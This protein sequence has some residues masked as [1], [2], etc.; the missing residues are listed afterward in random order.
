MTTTRLRTC[1]LCEATCGLVFELEDHRIVRVTGDDQHP[2]SQGYLCPKGAA[3]GELDADPDRLTQ[4]RIR[5]GD[6]WR[7]VDWDEA[8]AFIDDR[9]RHVDDTHG[10]ESVALYL[11]NPNVHTLAGQLYTRPFRQALR[12][13]VFVTASTV[14][15]M[16]KHR[17]CGEMFGDPAAIPVPDI[18]RTDFL[19]IIG[20]DPMMSNGS[21]WT[22][23]DI[24]GRLR[25]LRKRGGRV[26]VV[27]PRRSRTAAR[28]DLHL[29]IRPTTDAVL[30]AA[31]VTVLFDERLVDLGDLTPHVEG[32]DEV[33]EALAWATPDVA[34]ATCGIEAAQIRSLARDLA[35][36]EHAVVYGR[37]GTT[38]TPYGTVASWL[39]DVLNVLTGNLDRP[40]GAMFPRPWHEDRSGRP[41]ARFGRFHS[42]V[43]NHPEVLGE[44]PVAALAEEITTPGDGQVRALFC[45]AGNPVLSTPDGPVL[46]AAL[47]E[48]DLMVAVDPYVTAT[49][50]RAH[51]ILPP[52]PPRYSGHA[53]L[54]FSGLAVRNV[55]QY[56]PPVVP[57]PA[58]RPSE[59]AI[60]LRL[61]AIAQG[62]GP[63]VDVEA[64]D[65]LVAAGLAGQLA[66]RPTAR[67]GD[68]EAQELLAAVA[69][70][71]GA[72]RL[73]DLLLRS[74]PY[75]DA[76]GDDPDGWSLDRLAQHPH[77]VDLGALEPRVPGVLTTASG[78]IELAPPAILADVPR[79]QAL[80]DAVPAD[81]LLLIGRRHLRTNNSWG[82]NVPSLRGTRDMCVLHL[83]PDDAV[84]A[85][86]KDGQDVRVSS[87]T[88]QVVVPVEVT[89][90]IRPG[91]VS[92]PH[93][94][95]HDLEGIEL[96]VASSRPGA[97]VNRLVGRSTLD[98]LSGTSGLS[99]V[100]VEVAPA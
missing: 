50:R 35:A 71:R 9:L 46:D 39:V 16:P 62:A 36:A 82:Q 56:T 70:R 76:F 33:R 66:S 30:L 15:Q 79:L 97:N 23:P 28:A 7:D 98:P 67:T 21:V 19:L 95:G 49:S 60:L 32:V 51:V 27:D 84:A 26:V 91:V 93:G 31:M 99:G 45:V 89:D 90:D 14:D 55:L 81:A 4:P 59:E 69:P 94:F 6:D 34:A 41:P 38:T 24:P 53:D 5:S 1:P 63:S 11:G 96:A 75:G 44:F 100:P 29:P 78:R 10:R 58:D 54:A 13:G 74:G 86:V 83:H 42:R 3:F 64:V 25:A 87:S 80:P 88:G 2:L 8:F 65:D 22:V 57:L 72:E 37:L 92:L 52:P 18:D 77:G 73:I 47:G 20:A 43:G 40:G 17:S 48:L 12:P 68:R 85:G 61:A